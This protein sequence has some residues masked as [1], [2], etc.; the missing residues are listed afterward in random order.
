[1]LYK[2]VHYIWQQC[3]FCSL[4]WCLKTHFFFAGICKHYVAIFFWNGIWFL[5]A[6]VSQSSGPVWNIPA[7]PHSEQSGFCTRS[8]GTFLLIREKSVLTFSAERL[9]TEFSN[10]PHIFRAEEQ[11][12]G[13]W[14]AFPQCEFFSASC[15]HVCAYVQH[16]SSFGLMTFSL[17]PWKWNEYC[18]L[19]CPSSNLIWFLMDSE[20]LYDC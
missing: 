17:R 4:G 2:A 14:S 18:T 7:S 15:Q 8:D 12:C 1:M 6:W 3:W 5:K 9:I 20:S 13:Q 10:E 16:E 19:L 11:S